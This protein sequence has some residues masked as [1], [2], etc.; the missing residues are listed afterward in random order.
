M[1]SVICPYLWGENSV[2]SSG[3]EMVGSSYVNQRALIILIIKPTR[4]T[5]FSN[6]FWE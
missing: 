5:N 3:Y 2:K 1:E 4:C 6:L